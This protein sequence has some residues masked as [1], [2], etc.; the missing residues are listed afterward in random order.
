MQRLCQR[1]VIFEHDRV[2][3]STAAFH[4]AHHANLVAFP[5]TDDQFF[6]FIGMYL[7]F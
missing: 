3:N 1:A 4:T 7:F 5:V 2:F 6:T